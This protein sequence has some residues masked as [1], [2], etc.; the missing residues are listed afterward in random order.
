M[1]CRFCMVPLWEDIGP[2]GSVWVD[3]TGGDCCS[4]DDNLKNENELHS[5]RRRYVDI[6]SRRT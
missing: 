3:Y 6:Q 2:W 5:P 4:G 1:I